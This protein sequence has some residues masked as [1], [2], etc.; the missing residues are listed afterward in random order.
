M[1]EAGVWMNKVKLYN[2]IRCVNEWMDEWV[3]LG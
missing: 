2:K 1:D 3:K